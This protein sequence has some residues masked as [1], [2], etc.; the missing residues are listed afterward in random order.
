MLVWR[1]GEKRSTT[2][3]LFPF[4]LFFIR[5]MDIFLFCAYFLRFSLDVVFF[6]HFTFLNLGLVCVE[7]RKNIWDS[8]SSS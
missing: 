8:N 2:N 5:E 1:E 3:I 6:L 7:R 4:S